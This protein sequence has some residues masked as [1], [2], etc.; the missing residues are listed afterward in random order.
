M[1]VVGGSLWKCVSVCLRACPRMCVC[2]TLFFDG[3]LC[4]CVG[5]VEEPQ[6]T[7]HTHPCRCTH[8]CDHTHARGSL[9][10]S[11]FFC[12]ALAAPAGLIFI[13]LDFA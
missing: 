13:S 9:F 7:K 10:I 11:F 3:M 5:A 6:D 12:F 4:L 2:V 8:V 1:V